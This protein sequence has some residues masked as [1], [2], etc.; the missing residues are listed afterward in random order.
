MGL[1]TPGELVEEE[2][3]EVTEVEVVAVF[4]MV[5]VRFS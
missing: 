1:T 2:V 4:M 5:K 3:V